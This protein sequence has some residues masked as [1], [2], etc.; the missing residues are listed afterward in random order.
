MED[1]NVVL[2]FIHEFSIIGSKFIPS[3]LIE[4]SYW[5]AIVLKERFGGVVY[6]DPILYKSSCL[7]G[8]F[9]FDIDGIVLDKRGY[10]PLF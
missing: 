3:Y 1:V 8:N 5:F 9:L 6:Y 4:D 2:D 7:I 10:V